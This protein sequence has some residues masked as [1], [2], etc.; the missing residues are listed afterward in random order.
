MKRIYYVVEAGDGSAISKELNS[1]KDARKE[2]K[3]II[4]EDKESFG[5]DEGDIDYQIIKYTDTG[6]T[7]YYEEVR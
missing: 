1:L 6:D 7:V 2:L 3:L 5:L 4:K